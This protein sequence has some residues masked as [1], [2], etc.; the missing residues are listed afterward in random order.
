MKKVTM[1]FIICFTFF[2]LGEVLWLFRLF[3]G[4]LSTSADFV[5][6]LVVNILFFLCSIFGLIG[7]FKWCKIVSHK[8]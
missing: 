5:V 7:S 6:N 3:S 4:K 8:D 2:T 1:L